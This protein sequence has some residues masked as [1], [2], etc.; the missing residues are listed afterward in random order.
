MSYN[1]QMW[2]TC[3]STS[4][5]ALDDFV[6]RWTPGLQ[7]SWSSFSC[8]SSNLGDLAHEL[9]AKIKSDCGQKIANDV[10]GGV[11]SNV[12]SVEAFSSSAWITGSGGLHSGHSTIYAMP[13]SGGGIPWSFTVGE[14]TVYIQV[15]ASFPGSSL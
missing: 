9:N 4:T 3:S 10:A 8:T 11:L 15:S 12:N 14:E 6:K 5:E 1:V 7:S 13:V 2:L